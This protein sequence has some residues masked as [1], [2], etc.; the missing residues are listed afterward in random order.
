MN[1]PVLT[2]RLLAEGLSI[3]RLESLCGSV[4]EVCGD[5]NWP[6][7]TNPVGVAMSIYGFDA[8][9]EA[10]FEFNPVGHDFWLSKDGDPLNDDPL[11][12]AAASGEDQ[13]GSLVDYA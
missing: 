6:A 13:E 8:N 9:Q 12:A 7:M 11:P 10:V 2:R 3:G 4:G 1:Q 5:S